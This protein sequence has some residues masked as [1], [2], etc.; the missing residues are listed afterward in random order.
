MT[1]NDIDC[2]CNELGPPQGTLIPGTFK[3]VFRRSCLE[4]GK[5]FKAVTDSNGKQIE[6]I[7]AEEE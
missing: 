1:V 6:W 2:N 5:K 3:V 7:E 4:C